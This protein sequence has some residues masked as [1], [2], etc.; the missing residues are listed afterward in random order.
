MPAIKGA[1]FILALMTVL[2]FIASKIVFYA[3][4]MFESTGRM[5]LEDINMGISNTNLFK[6]FDVF[7]QP[8]KIMAE[9]EVIKS[10]ELLRYVVTKL[11]F[12]V[13]YYRIGKIRTTELFNET[14]FHVKYSIVD[15]SHYGRTFN[16]SIENQRSFTLSYVVK[17]MPKSAKGTFGN[18]LTLEGIELTIHLNDSLLKSKPHISI[19]DPYSFV[20]HS[21]D[22]MVAEA[23]KNLDVKEMDKDIPI[24]RIIYKNPVPE[25]AMIFTNMLMQTYIRDGIRVKNSAAK[26]TVDFIDAQMDEVSQKLQQSELELEQYRLAHH[27]TNTKLEVET[28][29]KKIAEMKI[30]L[31]NINMNLATLDTL[32][33]YVNNKNPDDFLSKAPNYEG[34]GGLLY[35]ELIKRLKTLQSDKKDLL[36]K[37]TPDNEKI[38]VVDEKIKDVVDYIRQNIQNFRNSME[39]QRNKIAVDIQQSELEFIDVPTK[40]KELVILER[41]FQLNQ[42]TYNFLTE[43]RTEAAIAQA[44]SMSFHRIIQQA[45]LPTVPVSPKKTFT[46]L[47]FAFLGILS[48]LIIVYGYDA[49]TSKIRYKDQLEKLSNCPVIADIRHQSK[50]NSS[51]SDFLSLASKL[52]I[53]AHKQSILICSGID[54]EGKSFA[55]NNLAIAFSQIGCSTLLVSSDLRNTSISEKYQVANRIGFTNFVLGHA[56]S[57]CIVAATEPNLSIMPCG[58]E[59]IIPEAIFAHVSFPEKVLELKTKFDIVIFDSPSFDSS[60]DALGL[61]KT[62]DTILYLFRAN[63][64]KTKFGAEPDLIA[65]EYNIGHI[66][67]IL[68]DVPDFA[69][70]KKGKGLRKSILNWL[71]GIKIIQKRKYL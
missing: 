17:E 18:P 66:K 38:K 33:F 3:T 67:L 52:H 12:D 21:E 46:I 22:Q 29:L 61:L 70:I 9:V 49:I 58:N 32:N 11:P 36:Q 54:G 34:Y 42:S 2:I 13:S 43:K 35:T 39:I 48:G 15:R 8:N 26:Q 63:F 7:T 14:P 20:I 71:S 57:E 44:A 47:V 1:P 40:E 41:N 56:V 64:T 27:I 69:K 65:Q 68:N 25:K 23:S 6:D 31:A 28:G 59:G 45:T 50:D 19:H 62:C 30:Q 37:Y 60:L 5:K 55:A 51:S 24:V 16:I 53:Q 4:P 10:T